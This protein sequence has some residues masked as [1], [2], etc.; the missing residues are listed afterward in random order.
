MGEMNG[1]T[2]PVAG[3]G[4]RRV[5]SKRPVAAV[6]G[7]TGEKSDDRVH[8]DSR[9]DF[10]GAMAAHAV[11]HDADAARFVDRP[12]VFVDGPDAAFVRYCVCAQ[13][14]SVIGASRYLYTVDAPANLVT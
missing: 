5:E 9:G 7:F 1:R 6:G 11:G 4:E 2:Q 3:V 10:P 8:G 14:T 12:T 13:H